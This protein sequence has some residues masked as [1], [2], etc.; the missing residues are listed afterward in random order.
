MG[1]LETDRRATRRIPALRLLILGLALAAAVGPTSEAC[2]ERMYSRGLYP[3]AQRGL[4]SLSNRVDVP[5]FDVLAIGTVV[6]LLGWWGV[7]GLLAPRERRLRAVGALAFDTA[8]LAACG[9]L[10]F[11]ACWGLNYRR[12]PI[13]ARL[14]YDERRVTPDALTALAARSVQAL[15]ALHADAHARPWPAWSEIPE[16]LGQGFIDA[17]RRLPSRP[18]ATLARPKTTLLGWY[19]R[20]AAIDGMTDP[21]LLETLVNDELLPFERPFVV[22]HEWAHLAGYANEAEASFVGWLACQSGD[23]ASRYS[24]WLFAYSQLTRQLDRAAA[25]RLSTSLAAGPARDL[26]AVRR[27]LARSAP[28]IRRGANRVYDRYLRANRVASGIASYGEVVDLLLGAR[29]PE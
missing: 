21:F 16:T 9:Y 27:R 13:R 26:E 28:A 14:D 19:F 3:V 4:T 1:E 2:V 18:S 11:L 10:L 22:A 15:N 5:L 24:A 29:L 17:E 8:V 12:E 6:F 20:R 25:G 23:A 7:R